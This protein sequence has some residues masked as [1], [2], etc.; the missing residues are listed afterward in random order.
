ME[1][2][3]NSRSEDGDRLF[4]PLSKYVFRHRLQVSHDRAEIHLSENL[5]IDI[6]AGGDFDQFDAVATSRKTARSVTISTSWPDARASL[7]AERD[8][9][10][11]LAETCDVRLPGRSPSRPFSTRGLQAAGGHRA[12]EDEPFG[13]L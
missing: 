1:K 6:D 12:A 8:L 11:V 4:N 5:R 10:D 9:I 3:W 7:A 2:S 13:V